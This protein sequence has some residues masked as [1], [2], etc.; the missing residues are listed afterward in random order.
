MSDMALERSM[1]LATLIASNKNLESMYAIPYAIGY[2]V[3]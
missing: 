3:Y 1:G 2:A